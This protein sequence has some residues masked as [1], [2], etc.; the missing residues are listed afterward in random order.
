M[1]TIPLLENF[2][3]ERLA[4]RK[5]SRN[6]AFRTHLKAETAAERKSER[7]TDLKAKKILIVVESEGGVFDSLAQRHQKGYQPAFAGCFSWGSDPSLCAGLWRRLALSSRLR[8]QDPLVILL[9]ALR[10][11]N[12]NQPSLRRAAVI[13]VLD[14][15]LAAPAKDPLALAARPAGSPERLILDWMTMSAALLEEEGY[16]AGFSAAAGF[17]RAA[18]SL[19]P[20]AKVLVYSSMPEAVALNQW[21]VAGLGDCFLRIA[22]AERGDFAAYLRTALKNGYDNS[23]ILV[24]GTTSIAWQAAQGVGA[25]FYP[26]LPGAEEESWRH[27]SEHFFPAFLRGETAL[28]ERDSSG[29]M[30]MMLED[31]DSA[32][33]HP[34]CGSGAASESPASDQAVPD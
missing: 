25:R 18:G 21:E 7:Q 30:R 29:F 17:L 4:A 31:V 5:R 11:L 33:G 16:A 9:A 8:G 10:I 27:L 26:I 20:E 32:C 24:I 23:P 34:A 22:G 12:R 2:R 6:A 1:R 19:A 3:G 14:A 15:Y 28:V 13:K